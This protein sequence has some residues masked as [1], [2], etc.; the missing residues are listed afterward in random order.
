MADDEITK[1]EADRLA[2]IMNK[3]STRKTAASARPVSWN[4]HLTGRAVTGQASKSEQEDAL[5]LLQKQIEHEEHHTSPALSVAVTNAATAEQPHDKKSPV[6]HTSPRVEIKSPLPTLEDQAEL[7]AFNAFNEQ[8]ELERINKWTRGGGKSEPVVKKD[9]HFEKPIPAVLMRQFE[10][11]V[12]IE[13]K[14]EEVQEKEAAEINKI[15]DLVQYHD[16]VSKFSANVTIAA[17]ALRQKNSEALVK[18]CW[19]VILS[20]KTLALLAGDDA[21]IIS[22]TKALEGATNL[23]RG[24]TDGGGDGHEHYSEVSNLLGQLYLSIVSLY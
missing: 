12:K 9:S 23:L 13:P 3:G 21:D 11:E 1:K 17:K 2:R 6:V 19:A 22:Y 18:A 4:V 16:G 20:A 8:R 5:R 15:H 7:N 14:K 10:T 24:R